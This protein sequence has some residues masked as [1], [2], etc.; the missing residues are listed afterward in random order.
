MNESN[1]QGNSSFYHLIE[2]L[3]AR[4]ARIEV[5]LDRLSDDY[6]SRHKHIHDRV[7]AL[8]FHKAENAGSWKTLTLISGGMA[9][10]AGIAT[11]YLAKVFHG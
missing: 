1:R 3:D 4:L 9:A 11:S 7:T 2:Q 6:A 8:E 10:I 5:T